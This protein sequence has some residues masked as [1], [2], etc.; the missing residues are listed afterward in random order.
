MRELRAEYDQNS[1][2]KYGSQNYFFTP[3]Q[4]LEISRTE[5]RVSS[6]LDWLAQLLGWNGRNYWGNLAR[7][8]E[9][10]RNLQVGSFGFYN[11]YVYP[12]V[13]EIRGWENKFILKGEHSLRPNQ[14][15]FIGE[16]KLVISA[17]EKRGENTEVTVS[18]LTVK[19]LESLSQGSQLRFTEPGKIPPPFVR[20]DVGTSGDFKFHVG[21]NDGVSLYPLEDKEEKFPFLVNTLFSGSRY[22]FDKPLRF[23]FGE[24][25]VEPSYDFERGLWWLEVPGEGEN[26]EIP[27]EGNLVSGG[28]TL[29][30]RIKKWEDPSDWVSE[31]T[32]ENFKG[33]WGDKGGKLPLHF[34]F[35]ALSL[36]GL[37][38]ELSVRLEPF[39]REIDFD[40]LLEFVYNQKAYIS[41]SPPDFRGDQVWWNSLTGAFSVY[42]NGSLN[43]GPWAEIDYPKSP[44]IGPFRDFVFPDSE[45]F[46]S[47]IDPP[48]AES[49]EEIPEGALVEV[50]DMQGLNEESG[51]LGVTSPLNGPGKISLY[52]EGNQGFWRVHEIEI[53][54]V[55]SFGQT[56][57]SLPPNCT[58][59]LLNSEGL[60]SSDPGGNFEISNLKFDIHERQVLLLRK[61][62]SEGKWF[63]SP[64]AA[65]KYIGNTRLFRGGLEQ[66][67]EQGELSWDFSNQDINTR[68]ARI[69]YYSRWEQAGGSWQLAG[70]WVSVK[71]DSNLNPT[72][73]PDFINFGAVKVYCNGSPLTDGVSLKEYDYQISYSVNPETGKFEFSYIP[74]T[75]RG[76]IVRPRITISDSITGV[77]DFDVSDYVFSGLDFKVTPNVEDSETLLRVWKTNPLQ[78]GESGSGLESLRYAN[79]LRA[80]VNQGPSD[81]VWSRYHL[82]LSPMYSRNGVDWQKV[83][84]VCQNFGYWGTPLTLEE[85]SCPPRK[86]EP[87]V[88]EELILEGVDQSYGFD[89]LYSGPYLYSNVNYSYYGG[90]DYDNSDI[91][92]GFESP[93]D[94]FTEAELEEYSPL[95]ERTV[96]LESAVGEGFG[97]WQGNYYVLSECTE[98]SGFLS[99]D[100]L[101][102]NLQPVL[103]PVWDSSIYKFPPHC[104]TGK[105]SSRVDS[106]NYVIGYAFFAADLSA[107]GE[108]V[109]DL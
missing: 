66:E 2:E 26:T 96:D 50:L 13:L 46:L 53:Q 18:E 31:E 32:L 57:Q 75:H 94:G 42:L 78:V 62:E 52:R 86:Q 35:D 21:L 40:Q 85:M 88:Y 84:L 65:L 37:N 25:L 89:V 55:S 95:N 58:V 60:T 56:S 109:F 10:K 34:T 38:E 23:S 72:F 97:D 14:E 83:S 77:F 48:F 91:L 12:E 9:D 29:E 70:D 82:R 41:P 30:V 63:I 44:L 3:T 33:V 71:G 24:N 74:I 90:E 45:S 6:Q 59:R 107:A 43:C 80:D 16:E 104:R 5:S 1:F 79:V 87:K 28:N 98:L 11:G 20:S 7:S 69:F 108:A 106:N 100:A 93:F 103:P 105:D 39:T 81:P 17:S 101:L 76:C 92:P 15:I 22:W 19:S 64:P 51:I 49:S 61:D 68:D 27:L 8:T 102:G 4:Q 47:Y 54:D 67:P 99:V 36:H 73:N